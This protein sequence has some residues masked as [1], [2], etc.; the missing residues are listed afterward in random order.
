MKHFINILGMLLLTLLAILIP[1]AITYTKIK[2]MGILYLPLT[3][4]FILWG[5]KI[6]LDDQ[7]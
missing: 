2:E 4:L 6:H 5:T 3:F 7:K 1:F